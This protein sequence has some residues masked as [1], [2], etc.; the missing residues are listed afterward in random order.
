MGGEGGI[1]A[2]SELE[3]EVATT[4]SSWFSSP[5]HYS[6]HNR[7]NSELGRPRFQLL[8]TQSRW[9]QG[10]DHHQRESHSS[11]VHHQPCMGGPGKTSKWS[12]RLSTLLANSAGIMSVSCNVKCQHSV[13]IMTVRL[14][15]WWLHPFVSI[16]DSMCDPPWATFTSKYREPD[17]LY[18]AA[19]PIL[20]PPTSIMPISQSSSDSHPILILPFPIMSTSTSGKNVDFYTIFVFRTSSFSPGSLAVGPAYLA[21]REKT[22]LSNFSFRL[23]WQ[24]TMAVTVSMEVTIA[25]HDGGRHQ[26]IQIWKSPFINIDPPSWC[27]ACYL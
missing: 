19:R 3:R 9:Q 21:G 5:L 1:R 15:W 7:I 27:L 8:L 24:K 25:G 17:H 13:K 18:L 12:I 22:R 11:K 4:N 6:S 2:R 10:G 26:I 16:Y 23:W 14:W 20:I